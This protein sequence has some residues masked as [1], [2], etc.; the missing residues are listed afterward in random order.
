MQVNPQ[1]TC[2]R[3]GA[4]HI[5]RSLNLKDA[6][7]AVLAMKEEDGATLIERAVASIAVLLRSRPVGEGELAA[8]EDLLEAVAARSDILTTSQMLDMLGAH[9]QADEENHLVSM[10]PK[11]ASAPVMR[12]SQNRPRRRTQPGAGFVRVPEAQVSAF[13]MS[14]P[15]L[16]SAAA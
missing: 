4:V 1:D 9:Q 10:M 3:A 14:Q 8:A 12:A 15:V 6:R 13:P 16:V 7:R 2:I 11:T 5:K